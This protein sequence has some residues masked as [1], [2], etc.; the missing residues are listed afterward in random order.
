MHCGVPRVGAEVPWGQ[1]KH[2]LLPT[3]DEDPA[4]QSEQFA[5]PAAETRQ[6]SVGP[7]HWHQSELFRAS[8]GLPKRQCREKGGK[9]ESPGSAANVPLTQS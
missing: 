1:G 5:A 4:S 9:W 8:I 6:S 7:N 2:T 3:V